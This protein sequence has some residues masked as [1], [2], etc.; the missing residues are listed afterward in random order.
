MWDKA[1]DVSRTEG[2]K[3]PLTTTQQRYYSQQKIDTE[4]LKTW[5]QK[6]LDYFTK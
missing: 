6:T 3:N 1:K 5:Y 2:G 4:R